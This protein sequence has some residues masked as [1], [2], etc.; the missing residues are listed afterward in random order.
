MNFI[1]EILM[2]KS[3]I[4][5]KKN[6]KLPFKLLKELVSDSFLNLFLRD[7]K[8]IERNLFKR[9]LDDNFSDRRNRIYWISFM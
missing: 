5:L 1:P 3:L 9:V 7:S 2:T 8:I 6:R 4:R